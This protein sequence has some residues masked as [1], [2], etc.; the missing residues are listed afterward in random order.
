M[1][2]GDLY[3]L[4]RRVSSALA[5][6][7]DSKQGGSERFRERIDKYPHDLHINRDSIRDELLIQLQDYML[8]DQAGLK[9]TQQF[10]R[11][12]VGSSSGLSRRESALAVQG[13]ARTE[14]LTPK[15]V[16][17]VEAQ[18]D[19]F[20]KLALK[21][22][23]T[24][25]RG[26]KVTKVSGDNKNFVLRFTPTSRGA[27]AYAAINKNIFQPAKD[28][29]T[30]TL[31]SAGFNLDTTRK[32]N[33]FNVGHI[34]SVSTLKA[35]RAL[36]AVNR[37]IDRIEKRYKDPLPEEAADFIRLGILSKFTQIGSPEFAKQFLIKAATVRPESQAT[38]LTDSDYERA[39]LNDVAAS[40]KKTIATMP[41]NWAGQKSSDSVIDAIAS[42]L[43][44]TALKTKK[45]KNIQVKVQGYTGRKLQSNSTK[46]DLVRLKKSPISPKNVTPKT[47]G[48]ANKLPKRRVSAST[49]SLQ[50]LLP[51]INESLPGVIRAHMGQMG[52]LVNRTGRFS[53]S[54]KVVAI[55]EASL[56]IGYTYQKNP[57][58]V[59]EAQGTRDPRPLIEGSIRDL[60]VGKALDKFNLRRI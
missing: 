23:T 21:T 52:R 19:L 25:I 14:G 59:F 41:N 11:Q 48:I 58:Q 39:L 54:A 12:T 6:D 9:T 51:L 33:L 2:Q 36:S 43:L 56:T 13:Y 5:S 45:S 32:Q 49:F 28:T 27:S 60:A 55:D 7:M 47:F 46:D 26:I 38:N 57:Y 8:G 42:D 30:R 34:T 20:V 1:A 3:R 53:E 37:G 29:I 22:L 17:V 31:A 18:A 15:Q 4:L 16:A 35:V 40:L 44:R 50:S 10:I 24:T